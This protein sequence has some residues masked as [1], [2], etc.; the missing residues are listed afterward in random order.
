MPANTISTLVSYSKNSVCCQKFKVDGAANSSEGKIN[1]NQTD[2]I[3]EE[4]FLSFHGKLAQV[5]TFPARSLSALLPQFPVFL[6]NLHNIII[7][8]IIDLFGLPYDPVRANI[9]PKSI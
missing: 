5:N 2:D 9:G 6:S 8:Q 4:T 1:F 7:Q 3:R